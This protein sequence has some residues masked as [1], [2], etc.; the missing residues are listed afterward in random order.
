MIK[1]DLVFE[2]RA[3]DPSLSDAS[4]MVM[5]VCGFLRD[6]G[7]GDDAFLD[8]LQLAAAEALNNAIEHGCDGVP[9]GEVHVACR[10]TPDAVRLTISDPSA[11]EG[12]TG[13]AALPD[14]PL[15]EGGRGR[16]LMQQMTDHVEHRREDERHVLLLVKNLPIGGAAYEPG[17]QDAMLGAMTEE[18]GSSY[19]MINALIGLGELLAGAD[20]MS[21]F[22]QLALERLRE[23]TLADTVYVR[24]LQGDTLVLGGRV[25]DEAPRLA[26]TI[27]LAADGLEARV[28]ETG[29]EVTVT[30]GR[31]LPVSDPVSGSAEGIFVAPV[32]FKTR[33][34]GV[35]VLLRQGSEHFFTAA[36]LKVTRVVAEYLGIV[37]AMNEL[38]Q[39]RESEQRALRELEIAAEIQ[40]SLM[41]A[42]FETDS[43]LDI[44]GICRPALK[45]G[46]DYF[47]VIPLPDG[48]LL[49][50]IADV[51]GK[52][53]S[54]ALLA[55]MLRTNLR[56][57]IELAGEPGRLVEEVNRTLAPDLAKLDMFI[58]FACAWVAPD[59]SRIRTAN[60]GHPPLLIFRYGKAVEE[61]PAS[62]LP[63]GVLPD[64]SYEAVDTALQAGDTLVLFTDGISEATSPD[65]V[66]FDTSGLVACVQSGPARSSE[67]LV[68][69][70]LT[71]VDTYS[72]H[73]PPA[74][75]RTLVVL[76]RLA[77]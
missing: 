67:E 42:R 49:V 33:R 45:A 11:F 16:F 73:A 65:G 3:T 27:G 25:G 20:E 52:G 1:S 55:N 36:Q 60:A 58:T 29:E 48:G 40:L 34:R 47:D 9:G 5:S 8:Q 51:M 56:A 2:L 14:D 46:G 18:L 31:S 66:F 37:W 50:A 30:N 26:A 59:H 76:R 4:D 44:H 54:A 6:H 53:I 64:S 63:I 32:F 77:D 68:S 24:M 61:L 12:W 75:D 38:Q 41:P 17:S 74:D 57:K 39:R 69:R 22:L 62:G 23:L 70:L 35:L 15:A 28:F 71:A 21:A 19:E 7:V 10:L 43:S 13:E 72:H